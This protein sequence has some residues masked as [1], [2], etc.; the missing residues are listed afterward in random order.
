MKH[1]A[2]LVRVDWGRQRFLTLTLMLSGVQSSFKFCHCSFR[3][4]LSHLP[5][6]VPTCYQ[7]PQHP[8]PAQGPGIKQKACWVGVVTAY[9]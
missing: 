4:H 1:G 3:N 5:T 8:F 9:S 6:T 2:V 7:M